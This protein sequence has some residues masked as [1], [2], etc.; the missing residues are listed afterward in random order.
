MPLGLFALFRNCMVEAVDEFSMQTINAILRQA[1][2]HEYD[3][4]RFIQ[5]VT[6][7][8]VES[9]Y[10]TNRNILF[11]SKPSID[12]SD[13]SVA[14]AIIKHQEHLGLCKVIGQ[15]ST[16]ESQGGITYMNVEFINEAFQDLNGGVYPDDK[17]EVCL[18]IYFGGVYPCT[19]IKLLINLIYSMLNYTH[20][21]N[22]SMK[23]I[24]Q[25]CCVV[26]YFYSVKVIQ[27]VKQILS[28]IIIVVIGM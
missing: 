28:D 7:F 17:I 9:W 25:N 22:S 18:Y 15:S 24:M 2:P 14:Y 16:R 13:S 11:K 1:H 23:H 3:K 8:W 10:T 21:T 12:P 20:L 27:I 4:M 5:T 19:K 6:S 26:I